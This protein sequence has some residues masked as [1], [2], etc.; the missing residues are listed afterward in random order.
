[1][2]SNSNSNIWQI[3]LFNHSSYFLPLSKNQRQSYQF[4]RISWEEQIYSYSFKT[5]TNKDIMD[6]FALRAEFSQ[7]SVQMWEYMKE[8]YNFFEW[9]VVAAGNCNEEISS[10]FVMYNWKQAVYTIIKTK[11]RAISCL[12]Y[13]A[14]SILRQQDQQQGLN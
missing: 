12:Y 3:K 2:C 4:Q 10:L 1:M 11:L 5:P 13:Y 9:V 8:L 6:N 7:L 14:S